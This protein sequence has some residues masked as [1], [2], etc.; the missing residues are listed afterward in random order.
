M[1]RVTVGDLERGSCVFA[2][3]YVYMQ[4]MVSLIFRAATVSATGKCTT[5]AVNEPCL[6]V[7]LAWSGGRGWILKAGA[8]PSHSLNYLFERSEAALGTCY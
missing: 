1:T 3:V 7:M 2:R 5:G 4:A 6:F 8:P